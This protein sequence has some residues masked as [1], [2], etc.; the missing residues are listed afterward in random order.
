MDQGAQNYFEGMGRILATMPLEEQ[1]AVLNGFIASHDR[2]ANET[3][4]K[5]RAAGQEDRW[6]VLHDKVARVMTELRDYMKT[7]QQ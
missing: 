5:A 7:R 2:L 6:P 4:R 1:I 3:Q